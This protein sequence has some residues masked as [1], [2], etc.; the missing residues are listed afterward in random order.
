VFICLSG[1]DNFTRCTSVGNKVA[2]TTYV[3]E[4][5]NLGLELSVDL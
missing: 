4:G 5:I 3:L 1:D 2:V